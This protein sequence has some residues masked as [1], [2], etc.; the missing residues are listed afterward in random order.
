MNKHTAT[1]RNG[2]TH[3]R[4]SARGVYTH[5]VVA[6]RSYEN[7]LAHA[8][9]PAELEKSNYSFHRAYLDGTSVFLVK[10]SYRSDEAH[11]AY[12]ADQ[13]AKA[14]KALEGCDTFADYAEKCRKAYVA[15]VE[16]QKARGY[17]DELVTLGWNGSRTLAEKG[18]SSARRNPYYAEVMILEATVT[19]TKKKVAA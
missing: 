18:S 12:C 11:A 10:P 13:V 19:Q 7:A 16:G 3:T 6:R 17:Y 4:N 5:C 9:R 2:K 15:S 1:D 8:N 14:Q